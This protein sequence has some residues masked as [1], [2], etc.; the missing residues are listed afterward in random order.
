[1]AIL[2]MRVKHHLNTK[3]FNASLAKLC[4]GEE[5]DHLLS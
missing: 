4:C 5:L 2:K 3:K 1:M